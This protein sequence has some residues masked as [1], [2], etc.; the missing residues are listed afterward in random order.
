MFWC[1]SAAVI[2]R[3]AL[4]D[5]GGVLT[6]TVAEDFHTTIALHANGWTTHYHDEVLVQGRAPHD[7]DSFLLQRA[8]GRGATSQCSARSRTRCGAAA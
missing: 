5:V 2:R 3:Q 6:D 7:L 1:G 4:L 8:R